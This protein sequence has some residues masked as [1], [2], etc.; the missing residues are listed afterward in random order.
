M[1]KQINEYPNYE[2]GDDGTVR[3]RKTKTI[4]KERIS[5][6]GYARVVL[7]NHKGH[8]EL[9]VHRLVAEAFVP[10]ENLLQTDV[11]HINGIKRNNNAG[12]LE[13]CTKS[14]NIR[15]AQDTGLKTYE[16]VSRKV[17]AIKDGESIIFDSITDASR[18]LGYSHYAVGAAMK[19]KKKCKGYAFNYI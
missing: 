13:W 6:C 17:V 8:K 9:A 2:V 14:E 10:H 1:W 4:L 11:N 5:N 16:A 15:H 7:Y 18:F 3:N 12:N 19:R